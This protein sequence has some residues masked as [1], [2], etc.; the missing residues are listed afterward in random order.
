MSTKSDARITSVERQLGGMPLH[1]RCS[2]VSL[3]F[4]IP[5]THGRSLIKNRFKPP[6]TGSSYKLFA[7]AQQERANEEQWRAAEQPAR[8]SIDILQFPNKISFPLGLNLCAPSI[9]RQL[10][11][12]WLTIT[13]SIRIHAG[14]IWAW[15]GLQEVGLLNTSPVPCRF[16]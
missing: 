15:R 12:I 13:T 6:K 1:L 7:T 9:L 5:T 4:F 2:S 10:S 3:H 8:F 11:I 16:Q 14:A